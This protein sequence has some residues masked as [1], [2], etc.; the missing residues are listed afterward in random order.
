[1]GDFGH[2]IAFV[3]DSSQK[4]AIYEGIYDDFKQKNP[5]IAPIMRTLAH[6]DDK[7][8]PGLQAADMIANF[9]NQLLKQ[10]IE[11]APDSLTLRDS[12]PEFRG[13]M[14]RVSFVE[15]R[16]LAHT[17]L[18]QIGVDF[19]D[20]LGIDRREYKSDTEIEYEQDLVTLRI[21]ALRQN[22]TESKERT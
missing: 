15:K 7:K 4:A 10:D 1:M 9:V 5:E 22:H 17:L 20:K 8:W 13:V 6:M 2:Q 21:R 3:S 16:W 19:L 14:F 11:Q 12:I 18:K